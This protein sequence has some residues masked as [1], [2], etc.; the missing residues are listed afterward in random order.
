LALQHQQRI[1]NPLA[2]QVNGR[3]RTPMALS[4]AS[5][6]DRRARSKWLFEAVTA[7]V[8]ADLDS[9]FSLLSNF[10]PLTQRPRPSPSA[11]HK[12]VS[13]EATP[14]GGL[15]AFAPL[16]ACCEA[17][18]ASRKLTL[19]SLR[20]HVGPRATAH[21]DAMNLLEHMVVN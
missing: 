7:P 8:E 9:K 5:V 14:K 11:T 17:Q 1:S 6:M 12:G 21:I 10:R 4:W 16:R 20:S 2:R 19:T 15:G 13:S 18:R 3:K